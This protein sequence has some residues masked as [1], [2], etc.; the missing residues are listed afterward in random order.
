M[1]IPLFTGAVARTAAVALFNPLEL[2]RTKMQ[3]Q[4]MSFSGKTQI[5]L[6]FKYFA[7]FLHYFI[8]T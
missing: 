1:W 4:K 3:S 5:Y 7:L 6:I 8:I 2:V